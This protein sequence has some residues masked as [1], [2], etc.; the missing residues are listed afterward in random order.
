MDDIAA[1]RHTLAWL[2]RTGDLCA[3]LAL[4]GVVVVGTVRL[5][6]GAAWP[7]LA[8]W[9][10]W[11]KLAEAVGAVLVVAGLAGGILAGQKSRTLAEQITAST[12]ARAA[13]MDQHAKE[14]QKEAA[15][16]RLQLARLKFRIINPEQQRTVV[17]W[18][19]K[20]PKGPV[21]I[22]YQ[23]D[24]E[25]RSFATQIR[26]VLTAAGFDAKMQ[27]G[28]ATL[29]VSGTFLLVQDLQYP[30]PQAVPLQNAFREIHIDLDGQQDA[31][32]VPNGA[33]VVILVGSRRL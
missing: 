18:L 12:I 31:Q 1:L 21:V 24:D 9:P 32:L 2:D 22:L 26:D 6:A 25:P 30:P 20:A 10:N 5:R 29:S 14:L 28:P 16:L 23:G 3:I 27:Q 19:K 8:R 4:V 13:E 17:D 15:E 7:L 33:T 11:P